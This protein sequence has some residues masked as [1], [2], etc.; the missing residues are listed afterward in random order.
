MLLLDKNKQLPSNRRI[1]DLTAGGKL[2]FYCTLGFFQARIILLK[3]SKLIVFLERW[4]LMIIF[5]MIKLW[6]KNMSQSKKSKIGY[7]Y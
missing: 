3:R 7:S 2:T 1:C 4:V 6:N 5:D